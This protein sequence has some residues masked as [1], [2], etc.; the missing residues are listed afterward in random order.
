MRR[1]PATIPEDTSSRLPLRAIAHNSIASVEL[2]FT[3]SNSAA[4]C[5]YRG[6]K[7]SATIG[8]ASAPDATRSACVVEYGRYLAVPGSVWLPVRKEETHNG[9]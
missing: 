5:S 6:K 2:P 1:L 8:M 4:A 7:G 9:E 3:A